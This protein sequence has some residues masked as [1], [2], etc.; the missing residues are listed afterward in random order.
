MTRLNATLTRVAQAITR[1]VGT[2]WCALAFAA[3]ALIS[4]PDAL[5]TG[6]L[7]VIVGWIAQTLLQLVLLSILAVG[8]NLAQQATE[9]T[10]RE[11][12]DAAMTELAE[13]NGIAQSLHVHLTGEEHR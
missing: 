8:Q 6:S 4:L 11:T 10:I 5:A 7:V 9:Q 2:M 12:H 1:A 13:L 3:L